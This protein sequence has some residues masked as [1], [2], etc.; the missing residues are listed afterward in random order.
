MSKVENN[1]A[2]PTGFERALHLTGGHGRFQWWA[3]ILVAY[4]LTLLTWNHMG[5]IF[6]GAVP[7]HWC[8]VEA[9]DNCSWSLE[10]IKNI[11]IPKVSSTGNQAKYDQCQ[12]YSLDYTLLLEKSQGNFHLAYE[13]AHG[14]G[15]ETRKSLAKKAT[16]QAWTYDDSIYSSTIV[17]EVNKLL[18]FL[19]F[20]WKKVL[21]YNLPLF[22]FKLVIHDNFLSLNGLS[23]QFNLVCGQRYLA[24]S[25]Q[26]FYMIAAL[27]GTI[28]FAPLDDK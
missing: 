20:Y 10:Q 13:L 2:T 22:F 8:H 26:A 27:V 12:F 15:D 6:L 1:I 25:I 9:L 19:F 24:A 28:T 3:L 4:Q 7:D 16:C 18:H 21:I 14:S 11:S 23:V 17:T 5:Y